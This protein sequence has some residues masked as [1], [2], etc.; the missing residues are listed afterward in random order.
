MTNS[1]ASEITG[2]RNPE[3]KDFPSSEM[4]RR[5][6]RRFVIVMRVVF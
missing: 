3:E 5:G 6:G 4:K 2:G 1:C